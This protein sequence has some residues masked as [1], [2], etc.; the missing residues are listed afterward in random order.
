MEMI[1]IQS[2]WKGHFIIMLVKRVCKINALLRFFACVVGSSFSL[3][4]GV[5]GMDI[6][7]FPSL[8]S[9]L[10]FLV[11]ANS[12]GVEPVATSHFCRGL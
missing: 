9:D 4:G 12:I 6:T 11:M 7:F 2:Q 3:I 5:E 1:S 8:Q 10:I